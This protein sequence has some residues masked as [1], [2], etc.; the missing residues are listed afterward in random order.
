MSLVE[1]AIEAGV[2]WLTLNDPA[3]RNILSAAMVGSGERATRRN[4]S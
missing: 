4:P 3:R 1:V 2:G